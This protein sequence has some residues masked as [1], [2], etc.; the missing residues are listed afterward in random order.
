[1]CS[2]S[3]RSRPPQPRLSQPS[4]AGGGVWGGHFFGTTVFWAIV[5]RITVAGALRAVGGRLAR[6]TLA[7][8]LGAAP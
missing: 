1:V 5:F 8:T 4:L 3:K 6:G 2:T 7:V